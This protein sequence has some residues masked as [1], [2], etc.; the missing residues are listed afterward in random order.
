M[1][2]NERFLI[3]DHFIYANRWWAR[4]ALRPEF[5][6]PP[7]RLFM[8][9]SQAEKNLRLVLSA[10]THT[11]FPEDKEDLSE[12]GRAGAGRALGLPRCADVFVGEF[13]PNRLGWRTSHWGRVRRAHGISE[14][15][16]TV[17]WNPENVG[18]TQ[19]DSCVSLKIRGW[20]LICGRGSRE[21]HSVLPF[22]AVK[23]LCSQRTRISTEDSSP[24]SP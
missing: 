1:E 7:F 13:T 19:D 17:L 10:L 3:Q 23:G 21:I 18:M 14:S 24:G 4:F 15:L 6:I 22:L 11:I 9:V 16:A 20:V 5:N 2:M 8:W 12:P